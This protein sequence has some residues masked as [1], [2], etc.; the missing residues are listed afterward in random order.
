MP[1]M[2]GNDAFPPRSFLLYWRANVVSS[3]GTYITLFT[4]QA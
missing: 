1:F 4:L 2:V 3:F